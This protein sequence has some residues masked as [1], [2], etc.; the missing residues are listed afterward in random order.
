MCEQ[1]TV[2]IYSFSVL[3]EV[4][5]DLERWRCVKGHIKGLEEL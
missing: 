1:N 4:S 3:E 2:L 5:G